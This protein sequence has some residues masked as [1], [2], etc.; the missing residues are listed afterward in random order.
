MRGMAL[1]AAAGL[2]VF[3]VVVGAGDDLYL[4]VEL[5]LL[6]G[7]LTALISMAALVRAGE[8]RHRGVHEL[9]LAE[10]VADLPIEP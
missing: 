8:R 3:T 7:S 2:V 4:R 5:G 10:S 9:T 6:A 1:C